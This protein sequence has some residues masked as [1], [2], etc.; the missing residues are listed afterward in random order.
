MLSL[1][2][3]FAAHEVFKHSRTL[4]IYLTPLD[5]VTKHTLSWPDYRKYVDPDFYNSDSPSADPLT[6]FTSA[7]FRWTKIQTE[8]WSNGEFQLI[9]PC[10]MWFTLSNLSG[11]PL[12]K[13]WPVKSVD[14]R[15]ER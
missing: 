10:S 14:I 7:F 5:I 6:Y 13:K 9:D 2:D 12:D 11:G 1:Q 8:K 4:P 15:I 3:V